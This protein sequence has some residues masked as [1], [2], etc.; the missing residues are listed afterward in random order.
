[1]HLAAAGVDPGDE[2]GVAGEVL[3]G[4][5]ALDGAQLPVD[6]D[7]EDLGRSGDGHEQLDGRGE[8]DPLEDAFFQLVDVGL[9]QV[10]QLQSLGHAAVRL[11]RQ[12]LEE[13]QELGAPLGGEDVAVGVE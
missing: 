9:K 5:Q 1:M 3:G 8:F 11:R 13:L 10:E 7:G 4:R 2:A 6:D 12:M